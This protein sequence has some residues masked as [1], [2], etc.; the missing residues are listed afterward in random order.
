[1]NCD[2]GSGPQPDTAVLFFDADGDLVMRSGELEE[3]FVCGA[4]G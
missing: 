2:H 4:E 1:M 3:R